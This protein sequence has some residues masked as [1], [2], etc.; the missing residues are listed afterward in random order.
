MIRKQKLTKI[1]KNSTVLLRSSCKSAPPWA[2][3]SRRILCIFFWNY[4][5]NTYQYYIIRTSVYC[6]WKISP[7]AESLLALV[8]C[9]SHYISHDR[10]IMVELHNYDRKV[11]IIFH[12]WINQVDQRLYTKWWPRYFQFFIAK[13]SLK[14]SKITNIV[15]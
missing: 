6:P 3:E 8:H 10:P 15:L 1:F 7:T 4:G 11:Y 12:V 5:T 13:I 9:I 14:M 2:W